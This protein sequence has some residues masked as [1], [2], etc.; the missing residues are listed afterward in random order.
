MFD[1]QYVTGR[2]LAHFSAAIL[3]HLTSISR[4][5]TAEDISSIS[6]SAVTTAGEMN[7]RSNNDLGMIV[8]TICEIARNMG[9]QNPD[10]TPE[11]CI[12]LAFEDE[13]VAT[14][15]IHALSFDFATDIGSQL[16]ELRDVVPGIVDR[17]EAKIRSLAAAP[18]IP[19]TPSRSVIVLNPGI[20]QSA[21]NA[22]SYTAMALA[23]VRGETDL[24]PEGKN[25][26]GFVAGLLLDHLDDFE[27]RGTFLPIGIETNVIG[28]FSGDQRFS[29]DQAQLLAKILTGADNWH[30]LTN[31]LSA[32]I[33]GHLRQE[34]VRNVRIAAETVSLLADGVSLIENNEERF[35]G[36]LEDRADAIMKR[37][38]IVKKGAIYAHVAILVTLSA[39]YSDTLAIDATASSVTVLSNTMVK[40]ASAGS[41]EA[42]LWTVLDWRA[43]V[44]LA[45]VPGMGLTLGSVQESVVG[46]REALAK[47]ASENAIGEA[48]QNEENLRGA[49]RSALGA[50]ANTTSFPGISAGDVGARATSLIESVLTAHIAGKLPL[51]L[52]LSSFVVNMYGVQY[53]SALH[54]AIRT[55]FNALLAEGQH[56]E[57]ADLEAARDRSLCIAVAKTVTNFVADQFGDRTKIAQERLRLASG[58]RI[59]MIPGA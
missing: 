54:T 21:V 17:L 23:T 1:R 44:S 25:A 30:I 46:A 42:D 57:G 5:L 4:G 9:L 2:V 37:V 53:L 34:H 7:L 40:F 15:K 41:T 24:M 28:F 11:Q 55:E 6:A 59:R 49:I 29:P 56:T 26:E 33:F 31:M 39:L 52:A 27:D 12:D 19:E 51:D 18:A 43:S 58:S 20:P 35:L 10:R 36:L 16:S 13:N 38:N 47:R 22:Q 14:H 50:W 48:D 45:P 32:Q 8:D 3:G